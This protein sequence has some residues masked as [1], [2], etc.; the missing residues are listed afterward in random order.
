[1]YVKYEF[2]G[3]KAL[4]NVPDSSLWE[5]RFRMF[6]D[7]GDDFGLYLI[8]NGEAFE[9]RN[10]DFWCQGR[11]SLP[12]TAVGDLYEQIVETVAQ[13]I[14]ADPELRLIDIDAIET[15]L[16]E[17]RFAKLWL[18]KGFVKRDKNGSW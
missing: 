14:A 17:T 6:S 7:E 10:T 12:Y 8:V 1:M 18:E 11:P 15:E 4:V 5:I 9:L 2:I 13:R 16:I 3:D